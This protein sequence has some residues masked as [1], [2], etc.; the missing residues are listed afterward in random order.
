MSY[1]TRSSAR[2]S[3][4]DRHDRRR[5]RPFCWLPGGR[6]GRFRKRARRASRVLGWLAAV[7]PMAL[8]PLSVRAAQD[9]D[10][11]VR[12]AVE[13]A[14]S[15]AVWGEA[16]RRGD[17]APLALAWEGDRLVLTL[18]PQH[19]ALNGER[20]A[21]RFEQLC[22]LLDRKPLIRVVGPRR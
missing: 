21:R 13:Y 1:T 19:A 9:S 6:G 14:N 7:L 12:A 5:W 17:P 11:A 22:R 10:A 3:A 4:A 18:P 16:L 20:L 8:A 2:R 15:P